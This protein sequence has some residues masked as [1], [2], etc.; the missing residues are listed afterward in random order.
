MA[1]VNDLISLF[2]MGDEED[3]FILSK[4]AG[5]SPKLIRVKYF[6]RYEAGHAERANFSA[7]EDEAH[8]LENDITGYFK[9]DSL[10]VR[11]QTKRIKE[12]RRGG[13]GVAILILSDDL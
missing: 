2:T 1:D 4:A 7:Q 3:A 10:T 11:E 6:S 12:I 13:D 8:C 9:E 5:S